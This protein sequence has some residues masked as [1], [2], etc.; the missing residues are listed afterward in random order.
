[1]MVLTNTR[2]IFEDRKKRMRKM[3]TDNELLSYSYSK[4]DNSH[5]SDT[6]LILNQNLFNLS[7]TYLSSS[8][9]H[10]KY[11]STPADIYSTPSTQSMKKDLYS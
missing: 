11:I 9:S 7:F 2:K 8:S 6:I 3:I 4:N 5:P 1:M 10:S